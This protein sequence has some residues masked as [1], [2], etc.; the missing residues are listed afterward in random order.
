MFR[1]IKSGLSKVA[2]GIGDAA[3]VVVDKASDAYDVTASGLSSA[4]SIVSDVASSARGV[5][6]DT[7]RTVADKAGDA[8]NA[9]ASG[10]SSAGSAVADAASGA[11]D[12]IGDVASK[13]YES[14][15]DYAGAVASGEKDVQWGKVMLGAS[16][17]VAAVAAAPFTGGGSLLAG[18]TLASSLAGAGAVA[19]AGT[20][21]VAGGV[22]ANKLGDDSKVREEAYREGV[23]VTKAQHQQELDH[24]QKNLEAALNGLKGA[25][26]HYKAIIA[27]HAVAVATANCDG[28]ICERERENIEL[29]ISG[30]SASSIP[31]EVTAKRQSLYDTP[32]S[33][34]DAWELAKHSGVAIPVFDEII[35]IVIHADE[36]QHPMEDAFMQAWNGFKLA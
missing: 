34:R 30:V 36:V 20:A 11:K 9:T 27:M 24:L 33:I 21:A 23:K 1:T 29:F 8:I 7:A 26:E 35:Q 5:V 4:G 2:D 32:P 12:V 25:A 31:A 10:L 22:I 15:K 16:V 14:T 3:R 17:G 28:S 19:A 18:A 6:A 13:A